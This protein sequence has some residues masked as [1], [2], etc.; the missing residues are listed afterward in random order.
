MVNS[1]IIVKIDGQK[2]SQTKGDMPFLVDSLQLD[3]GTQDLFQN[4]D[5]ARLTLKLLTP[6]KELSGTMPKI[7]TTIEL[8]ENRKFDKNSQN[9][10]D[11]FE[12]T[13]GIR[14]GNVLRF[15][16]S[17][18]YLKSNEVFPTNVRYNGWNIGCI[19]T[20]HR[21]TQVYITPK[22][23]NA[24][25]TTK[26]LGTSV[27]RFPTNEP[28]TI[29]TNTVLERKP[30]RFDLLL[31]AMPSTDV[32][33]QLLCSPSLGVSTKCPIFS[34]SVVSVG[35]S[36]HCGKNLLTIACV[37]K[38]ATYGSTIIETEYPNQYNFGDDCQSMAE[39]CEEIAAK[40][41]PNINTP[42]EIPTT[43]KTGEQYIPLKSL[44]VP[45]FKGKVRA[46]VLE[47]FA[48]LAAK[49]GY[50]FVPQ[51]WNNSW[52][53][54]ALIYRYGYLGTVCLPVKAFTEKFQIEQSP[55]THYDGVFVDSSDNGN[56]TFAGNQRGHKALH[57]TS[58][59]YGFDALGQ[60]ASAIY[61]QVNTDNVTIKGLTLLS[62]ALDESD[63]VNLLKLLH[64]NTRQFLAIHLHCP[65][66]TSSYLQLN[67]ETLIITG[68]TYKYRRHS[69]ELT[70]S[71]M[72]IPLAAIL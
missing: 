16:E 69:W 30:G 10:L 2:I 55:S 36:K 65:P 72:P 51:Y 26:E 37:D 60:L 24:D 4:P 14:E 19:V 28:Q 17:H 63:T 54:T 49:T 56:G 42:L 21:G 45:K 50:I 8:W 25:G 33:V 52:D 13:G 68:G 11:F 47:L 64:I 35:V 34:G 29:F 39:Q 12:I 71:T 5:P 6:C 53:Y 20:A 70:F 58:G 1:N 43:K 66:F 59:F 40:P 18:M 67:N 48:N 15:T 41:H 7:G 44:A 27:A 46:T 38:L 3:W 61:S 57:I 32:T 62:A 22:V 9:I 23:I 31:E